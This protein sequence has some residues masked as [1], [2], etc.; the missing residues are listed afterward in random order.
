MKSI[1]KLSAQIALKIGIQIDLDALVTKMKQKMT[2]DLQSLFE[3]QRLRYP[4]TT[5][6]KC[7]NRAKNAPACSM[8]PCPASVTMTLPVTFDLQ[9]VKIRGAQ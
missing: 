6:K 7:H 5:R 3:G 9:K 4:K 2:F 8:T 1:D